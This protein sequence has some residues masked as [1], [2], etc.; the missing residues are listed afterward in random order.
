MSEIL[1]ADGFDDAI[2]GYIERCGQ[3]PHVIYD[4]EKCIEIL[5]ERDKMSWEEA[6]EFFSFNTEGA[7]VGTGTPGFLVKASKK[8]IEEFFS[9]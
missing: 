9:E 1:F 5:V 7:W 8:E 3:D 4:R 2:L 6:E